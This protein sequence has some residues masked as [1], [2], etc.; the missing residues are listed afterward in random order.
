M[1]HD[2]RAPFAPTSGQTPVA[3]AFA[4]FLR[5]LHDLREIYGD[6][7][8]AL[9]IAVLVHKVTFSDCVEDP[10][11]Q[12]S[13]RCVT[14]DARASVSRLKVAEALGIPRETVRRKVNE[15]IG[16]GVIEEVERAQLTTA[17]EHRQVVQELSVSMAQRIPTTK[18]RH[19]ERG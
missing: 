19:H 2:L 8:E 11:G 12:L 9:V 10:V 13:L 14:Q 6:D 4:A 7:Y 16:L 5:M 3:E 17:R 15:L 1:S 18:P